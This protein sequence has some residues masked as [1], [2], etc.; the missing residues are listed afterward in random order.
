[1]APYM[2]PT[3]KSML[4][5]FVTFSSVQFKR[6]KIGGTGVSCVGEGC[7]REREQR[8]AESVLLYC[9][10]CRATWRPRLTSTPRSSISTRRSVRPSRRATPAACR[11]S[12]AGRTL[13]PAQRRRGP[14]APDR[15]RTCPDSGRAT[16]R[17]W[18][19]SRKRANDDD[20]GAA[21]AT[22]VLR[23]GRLCM[24]IGH[25]AQCCNDIRASV[26]RS[27]FGSQSNVHGRLKFAI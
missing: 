21:D 3:A 12:P 25:V 15:S 20:D 18:W 13:F 17:D 9:S 24:P 14:A 2:S 22:A 4:Y 8:W 16:R 23:L 10:V 6:V 7:E 26:K 1:M 27:M 11:S 5:V 19:R